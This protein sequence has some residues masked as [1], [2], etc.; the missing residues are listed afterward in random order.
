M[1]FKYSEIRNYFEI[2]LIFDVR[3]DGI[4]KEY[5]QEFRHCTEED[6]RSNQVREE[7]IKTLFKNRLCPE[8]DQENELYKLTNDYTN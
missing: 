2:V 4:Y 3:E 7:L 6:F 1:K 5:I 8:I